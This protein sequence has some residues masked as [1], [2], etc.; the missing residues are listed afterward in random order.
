MP[1][2]WFYFVRLYSVGYIRA[3]PKYFFRTYWWIDKSEW[4]TKT[5]A[6]SRNKSWWI[7]YCIFSFRKKHLTID[8]K[9]QERDREEL[10]G[11]TEKCQR[12]ILV[13]WSSK[14]EWFF[15]FKMLRNISSFLIITFPFHFR[16]FSDTFRAQ[17]FF[18]MRFISH[19]VL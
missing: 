10:N 14:V 18:T 7:I 6:H 9:R 16:V 12:A 1:C 11:Y 17:L 2:A 5:A 8:V 3:L 15:I 4:Q 13:E 19:F